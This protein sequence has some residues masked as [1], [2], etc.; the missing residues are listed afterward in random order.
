M[1]IRKLTET[2]KPAAIDLAWRVFQAYEAPVY[3]PEGVRNFR[4]YITDPAAVSA[5]TVYGAF[6][7]ETVI[8]ALAV[9]EGG[10]HI[11]RFFVDPAWHQKGV[12]KALFFHFLA[13]SGAGKVTVN[14]S[15]YAVEVYRRLGFH[16]TAAEQLTDGIRYTPMEYV[17]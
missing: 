12:G 6:E 4:A 5:L 14:S 15:P 11:S 10:T 16:P 8:G 17:G 2:E 1:E 13:D 9:R 7:G 3:S